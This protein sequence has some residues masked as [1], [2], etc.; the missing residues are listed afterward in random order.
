MNVFLSWSGRLSKAVAEA[1]RDW[2]PNVIQ[3]VEPW[4][5]SADIEKGARWNVNIAQQLDATSI[6]VLCITPGNLTSPWLLFEAGALSK[7]LGSALVCPYL[8]GVEPTDLKGPLVQFQAARAER[9]DTRRLV[10]SINSALRSGALPEKRVDEAFTV[11]WPQLEQRLRVLSEDSQ[12]TGQP[13]RTD[14]DI[15]E[16]VL[17]LLRDSVRTRLASVERPEFLRQTPDRFPEALRRSLTEAI[18]L[19]NSGPTGGAGA[20]HGKT[21]ILPG[22]PPRGKRR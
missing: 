9:D 2:L 20:A 13:L 1:L 16:E 22:K 19:L 8:L 4:M 11:W 18:A 5:S 14:R 7:T 21:S 15:L 10:H 6:G 17:E 3:S 12:D